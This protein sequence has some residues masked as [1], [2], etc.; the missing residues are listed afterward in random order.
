M[1]PSGGANRPGRNRPQRAPVL[2]VRCRRKSP[3]S[4]EQFPKSQVDPQNKE[5]L[6]ACRGGPT[7]ARGSTTLHYRLFLLDASG[8]VHARFGLESAD[9]QTAADE[10]VAFAKGEPLEVWLGLE[11]V[12][13]DPGRPLDPAPGKPLH[14]R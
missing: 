5:C 8:M 7:K 13:C 10:A 12:F 4:F 2:T 3:Y 14:G 9:N 11:M 1:S 6:K